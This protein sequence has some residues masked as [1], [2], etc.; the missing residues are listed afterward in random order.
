MEGSEREVKEDLC[1][2]PVSQCL[3]RSQ[4]D[5][6]FLSA[7]YHFEGENSWVWEHGI[8]FRSGWR[9]VGDSRVVQGNS[10]GDWPPHGG[11]RWFNSPP[12]KAA[13]CD[14]GSLAESGQCRNSGSGKRFCGEL[15]NLSGSQE[16][17]QPSLSGSSCIYF[18]RN[19]FMF[20]T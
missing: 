5:W 3:P 6:A 14:Q 12:K 17:W 18:I 7:R 19:Y 15:K 10:H 11:V 16:M 1:L 8:R 9:R 20:L 2:S 13:H 4:V